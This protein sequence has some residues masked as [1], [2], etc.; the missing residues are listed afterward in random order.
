MKG[1]FPF[2]TLLWPNQ[3]T[4][5]LHLLQD[6]QSGKPGLDT[7]GK[8][9]TTFGFQHGTAADAL[10]APSQVNLVQN[11]LASPLSFIYYLSW[12]KTS[13]CQTEGRTFHCINFETGHQRN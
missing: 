4:G 3:K 8:R 6:V 11:Y 1:A 9:S 2:V 10:S 5:F 7:P 12:G 13:I